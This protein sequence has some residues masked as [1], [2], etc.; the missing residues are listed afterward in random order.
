VLGALA[1]VIP[2]RVIAEGA[3]N[4]WLTT[5]RGVGEN[6]F[7]TVFFASGGTGAR[8]TKDGLS[9]TSFP[10]GIATA[11][12]EI[13][14][15]T[16]PLLFRRKEF[17]PDS[18]GAGTYR[19]GLGQTIE[20][21]VRTGEPYVVSSLA[22]RFQFPALGYAGGAAGAPGGFS[23]SFGGPANPKLSIR[24][25]AGSSFVLD[26][27]GGGGYHDPSQRREEALAED[28]AEGLVTE[29]GAGTQSGSSLPA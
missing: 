21:E 9:T 15:S 18:G 28:I 6:R 24:M 27:P 17:R 22:D 14:E 29:D 1:Q 23:T 5:V 20:V 12:I 11:P 7:V 8:P 16:S 26:L 2:E 19:G 25:P 4:V 13:I 3:G 10:S